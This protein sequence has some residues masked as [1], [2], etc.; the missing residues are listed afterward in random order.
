[1]FDFSGNHAIFPEDLTL[2][3][4]GLCSS[5]HSTSWGLRKVMA[6]P[7]DTVRFKLLIEAIQENPSR[8]IH[9]DLADNYLGFLAKATDANVANPYSALSFFPMCSNLKTLDLN[10]NALDEPFMEYILDMVAQ[11]PNLEVISL[12]KQPLSLLDFHNFCGYLAAWPGN[13]NEKLKVE[14]GPHIQVNW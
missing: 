8:L 7:Q 13:R 14:L 12:A 9:L 5:Q 1:M 11:M 4:E 6:R 2:M 10:N 3:F